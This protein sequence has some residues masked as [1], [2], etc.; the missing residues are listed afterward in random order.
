[1]RLRIRLWPHGGV[2]ICSVHLDV[3]KALDRVGEYDVCCVYALAYRC[4]GAVRLG[5]VEE[6]NGIAVSLYTPSSFSHTAP[7]L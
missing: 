2:Y 3:T 6:F 4:V 7:R 1:M 5:S